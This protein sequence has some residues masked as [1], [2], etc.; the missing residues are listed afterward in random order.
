MDRTFGEEMPDHPDPFPVFHPPHPP[1]PPSF[2]HRTSGT[3]D[4]EHLA[5]T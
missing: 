2:H 4:P 5:D 1:Y 3:I